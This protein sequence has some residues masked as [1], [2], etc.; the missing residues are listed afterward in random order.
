MAN[1]PSIVIRI[2]RGLIPPLA[3]R[4]AGTEPWVPAQRLTRVAVAAGVVR[5]VIGLKQAMLR[6]DPSDFLAHIRAQ[7]FG[8]HGC[9]IVGG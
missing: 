1:R 8:R 6:H 3:K 7:D 2:K 4:S 9:V 5:V